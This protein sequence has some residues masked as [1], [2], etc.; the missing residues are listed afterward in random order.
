MNAFSRLVRL[1]R[2][3]RELAEE[4]EAHILERIDELVESGMERRE[5]E[6][7]ARREF[8]NRTA[9]LES[10]RDAWS[11]PTLESFFK[12][13]RYGLR[14]LRRRPGF[15]AVVIA[16]LALGLGANAAIFALIDAIGFR[17]M[18]VPHVDQIARIFST[19]PQ[20][21]QGYFS[22]PEYQAVASQA[23]AFSSVVAI[24]GRGIRIKNAD[25]THELLLTNIVSDNF[26]QVLG[27]RPAVGRLFDASEPETLKRNAVA[28]LGYTFWQR[29]FGGRPD[30][31]GQGL[32]V[33]RGGREA[34]LTII[35]ALPS[36]FRS[37]DAGGDRDLWLPAD[38]ADQFYGRQDFTSRE[39]RWFRLL[40]RLAPGADVTRARA[41]VRTIAARM[42]QT[43][44]DSNAG[45][46]AN[47]ISDLDYRMQNA[48]VMGL[49]MIGA[50]FLVVL[51]CAL[52]IVNLLLARN[53][54]RRTE[55]SIRLALGVHRFRLVRQLL[56][57]NALLA[58]AGLGLGI[59][60]GAAL[61]QFLPSLFVSPPGMTYSFSVD[62][63]SRVV[64]YSLAIT[65]AALVIFGVMPAW[66]AA[67]LD[68][69][70]Q[71]KSAGGSSRLSRSGN[72]LRR[73]FVVAQIA[74]SLILLAGAGLMVQ[75][76]RNSRSARSGYPPR[77][78][79]LA[80]VGA[81]DE[82]NRAHFGVILD[83]IRALGG[84]RDI[85]FG[86]RAPLSLSGGGYAQRV[87]FP[88]RGDP[89]YR[90]PIEIKFNSVS[91]NFLQT[92]GVPV[93]RG[94]GFNE[95]DQTTGP[96]TV[97]ISER[98]AQRYWPGEDP[99]GKTIR[100]V[101][102]HNAEYRVIGIVRDAPINEVGE[103]TEPYMYFP[104][105][106][107]VPSEFTLLIDAASDPVE[108]AAP[109]RRALM[110]VD[111]RLEPFSLVTFTD[112]LRFS[113]NTYQ[114]S[115]E[116]VTSLGILALLITAVGLYGVVSFSVSQRSR[117]I[118]I[119]MALGAARRE[120]VLLVLREAAALAG[121]GALVGLPCAFIAVRLSSAL[122]FGV[123]P[124]DAATFLG[125]LVV[126]AAVLF[127]AA[128]APARRASHIDPMAALRCE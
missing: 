58:A 76:L 70:P 38:G 26:F 99:I 16:T 69:G 39:F 79:L 18:A 86:I 72:R 4:A 122:L 36:T 102:S 30:V 103:I 84:V 91:S 20:D 11:F 5:A 68:P 121:W 25:N 2:F 104:F 119:R 108:L 17:P 57:E 101:D 13:V 48:G 74:V 28:V 59:A 90:N 22:Y 6:C 114:I 118:G 54:S 53:L 112:L 82:M 45:R 40:G 41:Q 37:V 128:V 77:P 105:W 111:P 80:F 24:G 31:V 94:R 56:T 107:N 1:R 126:L 106:R 95:L 117:E 109:V 29:H 42:A 32:R 55:F 100:L 23:N 123:G 66:R 115:A 96:L 47:V 67:R 12:D 52:N 88:G 43:W 51:L 34:V 21:R 63:S 98:M 73:V 92:L 64:V 14:M 78:L 124:W 89:Q 97:L 35:G 3:D 125:A 83:R 15:T 10:S 93:L 85:A 8:G 127:F 50:A 61:L 65:L 81:P 27:V 33:E 19:T 49:A 71:L 116:L 87:I 62:L 60:M 110:G 46:S 120:T 75:S 44:P 9:A 113:T 7:A